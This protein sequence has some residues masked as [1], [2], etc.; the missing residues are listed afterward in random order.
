MKTTYGVI[1][2]L[3]PIRK[4][5]NR[6]SA[7]LSV[8]SVTREVTV[9]TTDPPQTL[10][11]LATSHSGRKK[12][13]LNP[14]TSFT[15]S[16]SC[17]TGRDRPSFECDRA[18]TRARILRRRRHQLSGLLVHTLAECPEVGAE[19]VFV[20]VFLALD[21]GAQEGAIR[22]LARLGWSVHG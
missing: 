6:V 4:T 10:R 17:L 22:R 8:C 9:A 19:V 13:T 21:C 18:E 20:L 15:G 5:A 3:S 12:Q 2:P 1:D 11:S 14:P 16:G 7:L